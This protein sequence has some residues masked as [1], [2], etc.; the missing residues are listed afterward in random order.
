MEGAA[1]QQ[2]RGQLHL[3]DGPDL[4]RQRLRNLGT[5][6]TG[7]HTRRRTEARHQES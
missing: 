3:Q 2:R 7:P 4:R 5:P 1:L 6:A